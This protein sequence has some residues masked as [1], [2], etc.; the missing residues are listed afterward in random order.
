MLLK[1]PKQVLLIFFTTLGSILCAAIVGESVFYYNSRETLPVDRQVDVMFVLDVNDQAQF[2]VE[3]I[4]QAVPEFL[5]ELKTQNLDPRVGLVAFRE[6]NEVIPKVDISFVLDISGSMKT[7]VLTVGS[8]IRSFT[9]SLEQSRVDPLIGLTTFTDRLYK[10]SQLDICF[11]LDISSDMQPEVDGLRDGIEI[12]ANEL[13]AN[14]IDLNV[15]LVTFNNFDETGDAA[16]QP[17]KFSGQFLTQKY[18]DIKAKLAKI[19]AGG[20]GLDESSFLGLTVATKQTFRPASKKIIILITDEPPLIPDGEVKSTVAMIDTLK[21]FGA[22]D[23]FCIVTPTNNPDFQ[24]L[25]AASP[26]KFFPLQSTD[27]RIPL[28][29]TLPL[30]STILVSR[31][32]P[33]SMANGPTGLAL[34]TPLSVTEFDNSESFTKD[35]ASLAEQFSKLTA[36]GGNDL[37]ESIYDAMAETLK[38]SGRS[39]V[40]KAIILITDAKPLVPDLEIQSTEEMTQR[41]KQFNNLGHVK[42]YCCTDPQFRSIFDGLKTGVPTR[43]YDLINGNDHVELA[44]LLPK[45]AEQITKDFGEPEHEVMF[46]ADLA[47]NDDNP[48]VLHFDDD[49]FTRDGEAFTRAL[50]DLTATQPALPQNCYNAVYV[51]GH[52][53][54]RPNA[55]RVIV[56]VSNSPAPSPSDDTITTSDIQDLLTSR[57]ISHVHLVTAERNRSQFDRLRKTPD[58]EGLFFE[59][60]DEIAPDENIEHIIT[61]IARAVADDSVARRDDPNALEASNA[62]TF[63]TSATMW[64]IGLAIGLCLTITATQNIYMRRPVF[65][66]AELMTLLFNST[67]I[68]IIVSLLGQLVLQQ[69]TS[70]TAVTAITYHPNTL[71]EYSCVVMT[72]ILLGALLAKS[73][74]TSIPNANWYV[75]TL[76]GG[77]AASIAIASHLASTSLGP[78]VSRLISAATFGIC[79]SSAMVIVE[80]ISRNIFLTVQYGNISTTTLNLGDRPILIGSDNKCDLRIPDI[81]PVQQMY[82]IEGGS[83]F[84]VNIPSGTAHVLENGNTATLGCVKVTV[85]TAAGKTTKSISA[86]VA[87]NYPTPPA[88]P[89]PPTKPAAT[90]TAPPPSRPASSTQAPPKPAPTRTAPSPRSTAPP[91][92]PPKKA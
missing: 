51:A 4:H 87:P 29:D 38:T 64:M 37:P 42:L 45:V 5:A 59:I 92:P 91:P 61:D 65:S 47:D 40:S 10:P 67:V 89:R 7:E 81:A 18:P 77:I 30:I 73:L 39:D 85:T 23:L 72:W 22:S 55:D 16:I 35:Y 31:L 12:F 27:Q 2:A 69:A 14:G 34:S 79:F 6:Q 90:T 63:L 70:T 75:A 53:V 54:F 1:L 19:D 33:S 26:L 17:I 56:I 71:L 49:V 20:G 11:V 76:A 32:G 41:F 15:G 62:N 28:V 60:P 86:P 8:G 88:P 66:L 74:S 24:P 68:A 44:S 13:E 84:C 21:S 78:S 50:S 43:Y 36:T 82:F 57:G 3:S 9:Q 52:Q 58:T 80:R 46:L 25:D 83:L 48:S